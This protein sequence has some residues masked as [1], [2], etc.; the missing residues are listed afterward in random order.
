MDNT[1]QN[2][3][4]VEKWLINN[5]H[6]FDSMSRK[7]IVDT[8]M[9]ETG[10]ASSTVKKTKKADISVIPADAV[11]GAHDPVERILDILSECKEG[12][13]LEE[14]LRAA[15]EVPNSQWSTVKNLPVFHDHRLIV[16][17]ATGQQKTYWGSKKLIDELK[18]RISMTRYRQ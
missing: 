15:S 9:Q 5:E 6:L 13:I 3:P 2:P 17:N 16:R 4:V 10:A 7:Q 11:L 1:S 12:Y 18:G 8:C 14:D